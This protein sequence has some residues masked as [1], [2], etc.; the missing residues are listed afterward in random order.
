MDTLVQALKRYRKQNV[1][2]RD[3]AAKRNLSLY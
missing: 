1:V 2:L 3:C